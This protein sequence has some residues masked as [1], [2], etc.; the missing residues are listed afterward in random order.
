MKKIL[1]ALDFDPAAEKIAET[2]YEL[3]KSM[4]AEVILLHVT[5]EAFYYSS[6]NYSPIMGFDGFSN[7]S[8][9]QPLNFEALNQAARD[10]LEKS[11]QHLGDDTIQTVVKEG[12][13]SESILETAKEMNVDIIVMGSHGRHGLDKVLLG[14]VAEQVLH[15]TDIPLFIIPT[16][17][18]EDK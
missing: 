15:K 12:E 6:Q 2:G 8:V 10:Y 7:L 17:K 5:A 13:F 18:F 11:K 16:K 3:A 14:S 1:I 4:S 9:A